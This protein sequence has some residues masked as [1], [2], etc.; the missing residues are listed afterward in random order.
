MADKKVSMVVKIE[1][2]I[3]DNREKV[4]TAY[5]MAYSQDE[6]VEYLARFL[7]K[8]IKVS[9][10][11]IEAPRVDALSDEVRE[12]ITGRK[13]I[14]KKEKKK[15]REMKVKKVKRIKDRKVVEVEVEKK[16]ADVE[17]TEE[18]KE[19]LEMARKKAL[20]DLKAQGVNIYEPTPEPVKETKPEPV[21]KKE[22]KINKPKITSKK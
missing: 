14:S 2:E 13:I 5:V 15:N 20:E 22:V 9:A 12:A 8:T 6:A 19:K 7:K 4:W 16:K 18:D 21:K 17:P 3:G 1:Y 11:G 10:V